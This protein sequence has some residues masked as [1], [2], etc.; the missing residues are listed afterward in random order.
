MAW[1]LRITAALSGELAAFMAAE[2]RTGAE[3]VTAVVKRQG[4][5]AKA[6]GRA[7]IAGAGL[8]RRLANTLRGTLY[9]ERGVSLEAAYVL[10]SSAIYVRAGGQVDLLTVYAEGATIRGRGGQFLALPTRAAGR[11]GGRALSPKDYPADFF[12]FLPL[13]SGIAALVER[14]AEAAARKRGAGFPPILFVLVR[15]VT[16]PA[17]LGGLVGVL[18]SFGDDLDAQIVAEW[19]RRMEGAGYPRAT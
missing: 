19:E 16:V 15:E 10:R 7:M 8:G 9:P 5:A 6:A 17:R 3:A 18:E 11:T 1:D 13:R 4:E 2:K 14:E 12:T